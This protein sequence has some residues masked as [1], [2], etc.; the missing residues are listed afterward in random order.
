MLLGSPAPSLQVMQRLPLSCRVRG[1]WPEGYE[2]S[3]CRTCALFLMPLPLPTR[4][5]STWRTKYLFAGDPSVSRREIWSC[6]FQEGCSFHLS[7]G[8]PGD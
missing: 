2:A 8:F 6:L 7:C 4:I 1:H 5:P 3:P